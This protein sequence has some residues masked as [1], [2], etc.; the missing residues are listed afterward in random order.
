MSAAL[1]LD[2]APSREPR[3]SRR[4][5]QEWAQLPRTAR[6]LIG[7]VKMLRLPVLLGTSELRAVVFRANGDVEDLGVVSRRVVTDT[8]VGF[9]VD[10]LQNLTEAE[11]LNFHASGTG[12]TAEAAS[13]TALVTEVATRATGTQSE[14]ASNQYRSVGTI[15]YTST[16]AITEHGLMSASSVGTLFDRSLFAAINVGN[17]DSIQFT[18]TLTL[19]SGG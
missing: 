19:T 12:T 8:G 15:S 7:L 5:E 11:N 4:P 17:G 10:A 18:Y 2:G 16:L 1:R 14:P 9:L 3:Y 13:Q 6:A